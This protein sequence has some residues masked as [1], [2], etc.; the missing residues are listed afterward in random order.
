MIS[1]IKNRLKRS[2][3]LFSNK[4]FLKYYYGENLGSYNANTRMR[5]LLSRL[6]FAS[7][8]PFLFPDKFFLM[9]LHGSK[10][11]IQ[12]FHTPI[13]MDIALGVYE[14]RMSR[15]F[16]DLVKE[17][18]TVIDVGA[19]HGQYSFLS[20]KLMNDKG[21]VHAFEPDPKNRAFF[22]K[23]VQANNYN[24]I[25]L[26]KY[27]LSDK[28][29][30]SDFFA[31]DGLGS[32][33]SNPF[34]S[35]FNAQPEKISVQTQTLDNIIMKENI[36]HIDLIKIDVEGAELLVLKG[37]ERSLGNMT[38][39]ILMDV[40]TRNN[41]EREEIFARLSSWGYKIHRLDRMLEPVSNEKQMLL[42]FQSNKHQNVRSIYAT[43]L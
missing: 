14:Y 39:N 6:A 28:E 8:I 29:G 38:T 18:M 24:S 3:V 21:K 17:G 35:V 13:T 43:K 12:P 31:A 42:N 5:F 22:T 32:F 25:K 30:S 16:F 2:R 27:A 20:A 36:Q 15:L 40:D 4:Y 26:H 11:Y 23:N 10:F 7:Q 33:Y 37:A 41:D 34:S 1:F 19:H 9:N